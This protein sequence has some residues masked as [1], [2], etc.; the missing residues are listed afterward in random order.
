MSGDRPEER[1]RVYAKI[2]PIILAFRSMHAGKAFHAE[3]LRIYVRHHA[4]EIAPD[5]PSRILRLL[6]EQGRLHYVVIDRRDSLYQ[7]TPVDAAP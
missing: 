3:E 7:F 1:K 6:R 2:A 4:P 5:S